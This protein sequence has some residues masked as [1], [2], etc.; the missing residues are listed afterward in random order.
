MRV[1][2]EEGCKHSI[3]WLQLPLHGSGCRIN[4]K[5]S[6]GDYVSHGATAKGT[7]LLFI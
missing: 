5:L 6:K 2:Q 7:L 3:T 1:A 4:S